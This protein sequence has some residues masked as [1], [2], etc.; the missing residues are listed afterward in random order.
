MKRKMMREALSSLP[1]LGVRAF[2]WGGGFVQVQ[3]V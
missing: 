2:G 3:R 1:W